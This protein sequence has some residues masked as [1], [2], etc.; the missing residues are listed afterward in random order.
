MFTLQLAAAYGSNQLHLSLRGRAA[1]IVRPW[2]PN[3]RATATLSSHTERHWPRFGGWSYLV[4]LRRQ[5]SEVRIPSGAPDFND[6]AGLPDTSHCRGSTT[7]A[8]N[9]GLSDRLSHIGRRAV[10]DHLD[11]RVDS[12]AAHMRDL[13]AVHGLGGLEMADDRLER[14]SSPEP[15]P[16][17]RPDAALLVGFSK[18]SFEW[19]DRIELMRST[20]SSTQVS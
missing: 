12:V 17:R 7:E 5:R 3:S 20:V 16:D 2:T 8:A 4:A 1:D 11:D 18:R 14:R 19:G 9:G 13:I 10:G 15:A 6:L